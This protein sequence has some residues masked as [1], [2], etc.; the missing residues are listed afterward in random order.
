MKKENFD[1]Q[2]EERIFSID[3]SIFISYYDIGHGNNVILF[4]HGWLNSKEIWIPVIYG[5]FKSGI[6]IKKY[7]FI[8]VDLLGHGNSSRSLKL[9]FST[10]EQVYILRRFIF[11]LGIRNIT[12]VGHS[13][14]GKISLF[15]AESVNR[16]SKNTIVRVILVN[17]IGSVEFWR[18][19]NLILKIA[20]SQVVR[21]LIGFFMLPMFIDYFSKHFLFLMPFPQSVKDNIKKYM[22]P[23]VA[24]HFESI[25]NKIVALRITA[26]IFDDFVESID[27]ARIPE[28]DI[29]HSDND[30]L[31][32]L[33][34]AYK[35][36]FVFNSPI[37]LIKG[38]GHMTPVEV[39]EKL[40]ELV[41]RLITAG[42]VR[43]EYLTS[44]S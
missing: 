41:V 22:A 42:N 19:L 40:S 30:R 8:I 20:V 29:I 17:A 24:T 37:Y 44:K 35:F 26:N 21:T 39:P 36:S 27:R 4:I 10:N 18:T 7:R 28:V 11:G 23:Y 33:R 15:L 2:F 43:K 31:V 38:S 13:M 6:N 34:V 16:L 5:I 25:S 9:S 1:I 32:D 3:D 14:G 12:I